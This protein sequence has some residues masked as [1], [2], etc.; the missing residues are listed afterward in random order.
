MTNEIRL[1][2]YLF[3]LPIRKCVKDILLMTLVVLINKIET[4]YVLYRRFILF[5]IW[6]NG[7]TNLLEMAYIIM[8]LRYKCTWRNV[9]QSIFYI[10]IWSTVSQILNLIRGE[11]YAVRRLTDAFFWFSDRF[12]WNLQGTNL[13]TNWNWPSKRLILGPFILF[14]TFELFSSKQKNAIMLSLMFYLLLHFI[15][16]VFFI[17]FLVGLSMTSDRQSYFKIHARDPYDNSFLGNSA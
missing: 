11:V 10:Y 12:D 9:F 16:F 7:R 14:T 6:L 3:K 2:F 8:P 5:W 15:L 4:I 1:L 17:S 13:R